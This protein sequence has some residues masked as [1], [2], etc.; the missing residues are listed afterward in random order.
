MTFAAAADN[1]WDIFHA[2]ISG[3][4]RVALRDAGAWGPL[5]DTCAR[6]LKLAVALTDEEG[7]LLGTCHN[8]QPVWTLARTARPEV[9]TGCPFCLAPPAPCTAVAKALESGQPMIARDVAGLTHLTVPLLLG[10]NRIGAIVAGQVFDRNPEPSALQRAAKILGVPG[11]LLWNLSNEQRPVS[12]A[13]LR[14]GSDLL[15]SLGRAF[16]QERYG[17]I[18]EAVRRGA[19]FAFDFWWTA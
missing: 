15:L 19:I 1:G 4:E 2:Q 18:L 12:R 5:L 13:A 10:T 6:T 17:T 8:P 14:M 3:E 9:E 11:Q 7:K 16:L